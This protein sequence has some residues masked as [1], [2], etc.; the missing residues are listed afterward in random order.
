MTIIIDTNSGKGIHRD[1]VRLATARDDEFATLSNIPMIWK[2]QDGTA[3]RH[4]IPNPL[5]HSNCHFAIDKN[6]PL[7]ACAIQNLTEL[8]PDIP[9][10]KWKFEALNIP[11]GM[12]FPRI[13]RPHHQHPFDFPT[14]HPH[15]SFP[16]ERAAAAI[17]AGA[18]SEHLH[19]CFRTV[20]PDA[21]NMQVF[22]NEFR[23]IL[24][25]SA[26]E[27]EAQCKGILKENK[28]KEN[29]NQNSW[30]T[31]DYY[32]LESALRLK[33]FSI[34]FV[35]FPWIEPIS[36]FHGWSNDAPTKSLSWYDAYNKTKHD[37]ESAF[38]LATLENCI[39]AVASVV[40]ICM[41]QF[42]NQ[43]LR[44]AGLLDTFA[45]E[46]RPLWSVGDTHGWLDPN[47]PN[48]ATPI[49]YPF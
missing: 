49:N 15:D 29:K 5:N 24:I 21:S 27:F 1:F 42:G 19:S 41:A 9:L 37:R 35:K 25:L 23:N 46:T 34:R 26:T 47:S 28:Y 2:V 18:L 32:K 11:I 20:D 4:G 16:H 14:P 38:K 48:D 10:E 22:G 7:E 36:P 8:F 40:T 45:V 33:D 43:F 6:M 13:A 31:T 3:I 17:Q 30:N 44:A 12:Y 39:R